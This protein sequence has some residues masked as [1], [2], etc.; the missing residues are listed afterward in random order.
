MDIAY[1]C[2]ESEYNIKTGIWYIHSGRYIGVK[3]KN[4]YLWKH[5]SFCP[6]C[7]KKT[8]IV[9]NS[10]IDKNRKLFLSEL[11]SGKYHKGTIRS[12]LKGNP[13]VEC[14]DDEGSCACAIMHDLFFEYKGTKRSRNYLEALDLTPKECRFIQQELNDSP[15]SFNEIADQIELRVFN[16]KNI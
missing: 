3:S 2:R 1:C 14:K 8:Q 11:R 5:I 9:D 13:I 10:E 15:L 16:S 12:D 7:G 4:K 6:F